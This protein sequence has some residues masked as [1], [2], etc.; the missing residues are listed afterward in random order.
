V[1]IRGG[2]LC[3]QNISLLEIVDISNPLLPVVKA[4]Y[5][6]KEPYGLGVDGNTL[7]VCDEGLAVFDASDPILSGSRKITHFQDIDGYDVI[8]LDGILILI[9]NDGMYQYDYSNI[10][11]IKLI[12]KLEVEKN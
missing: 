3:G 12:S 5:N 6:M 9:G 10:Q 11:D 8:P 7:F 2:N 4:A 1:T